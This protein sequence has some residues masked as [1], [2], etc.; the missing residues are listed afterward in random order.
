MTFIERL[1]QRTQR[2]NSTAVTA[3]DTAIGVRRLFLL[4]VD[5]LPFGVPVSGQFRLQRLLTSP[6][7]GD[8]GP[9]VMP[10]LVPYARARVAGRLVFRI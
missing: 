1:Q 3:S 2:V 8:A 4:V 9:G 7:V 10:G 6:M 5:L